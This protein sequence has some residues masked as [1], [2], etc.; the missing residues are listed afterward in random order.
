MG[1]GRRGRPCH[2]E[3][4]GGVAGEGV[5]GG[6]AAEVEEGQEGMR[7]TDGDEMVVGSCWGSGEG[8]CVWGGGEGEGVD[9][10]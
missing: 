8:V 9:R 2:R 1:R 3:D 6:A 10:G 5:C 7:G 4:G